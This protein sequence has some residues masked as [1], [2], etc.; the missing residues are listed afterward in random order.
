M[1]GGYKDSLRFPVLKEGYRFISKI[2]VMGNNTK[3]GQY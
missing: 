3:L 1:N 2:T